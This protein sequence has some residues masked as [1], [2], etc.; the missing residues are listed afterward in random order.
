MKQQSIKNL[1]GLSALSAALMLTG[2]GGGGSSSGGGTA[3][4]TTDGATATQYAFESKFNAGESSVSYGGQTVRQLIIVDFVN[5]MEALTEDITADVDGDLD[6]YVRGD[7]ATNTVDTAQHPYGTNALFT[8]RPTYDTISAGKN[9]KD[10][11]AGGDGV[12]GGETTKLINDEFFGWEEGADANPLPIELVDFF[13]AQIDTLVT[14]GLDPTISTTAGAV[15][16]APT[17]TVDTKGRDYRQLIQK[18]LLGAVAFSQ[19]TND[20]LQ[21]DFANSNAQD[22]VKAYTT[23]EHKWDE[24]FGYFGAARD[25]N[26]YTDLEIR[27]KS[28]R[29]DYKNGYHD[30]NGDTLI[31]LR[32]EINLANSTNCAKRDIGSTTGLNYTKTAFDAFLLGRE[33]LNN[34]ANGTLSAA[35]L[36]TIE[37]QA[38][39]AAVTWEKCIAATVIHYINDVRNDD[40]AA[41]DGENFASV[42][43]FKDLAKHWSEMKGFALGLQFSPY[44]PFR[45]GSVAGVDVTDLKEILTLMGDAPV[46]A[47]GS[48]NGVA[49]AGTAADAVADYSADLLAARN[50]LQEAYGFDA[51]DV[52]A[53]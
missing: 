28:G 37:E 24:A 18:F 50:K 39:I 42:D 19:G 30:T 22:G 2:C 46:L 20:Y 32:S 11:I 26:N 38:K 52:A 44:S 35:Q 31:D 51:A 13:V 47:D 17:V 40:M 6:F 45:D 12:G 48:Q 21:T 4:T 34:A 10:K 9:L 49:P 15:G 29:D 36:T 5:A 27:A 1:L 33:T 23:A 53:W 14:D 16:L 43:A 3:T 8:P 41:F 25:Y 7:A